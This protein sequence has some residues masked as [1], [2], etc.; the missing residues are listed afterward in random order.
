MAS[1]A[2][3]FFALRV[4]FFLQSSMLRGMS[5]ET[6]VTAQKVLR[7]LKCLQMSPQGNSTEILF[8]ANS[9]DVMRL[10]T[11]LNLSSHYPH[12]EEL[13]NTFRSRYL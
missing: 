12:L 4:W 7:G 9:Q 10:L 2:D 1:S 11:N 5:P 3:F 13:T 6:I 8:L